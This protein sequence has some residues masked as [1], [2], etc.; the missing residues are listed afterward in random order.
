MDR[1]PRLLLK[2]GKLNV[3]FQVRQK[4]DAKE[5]FELVVLPL[6]RRFTQEVSAIELCCACT[7]LLDQMID[8]IA[9]ETNDTCANVRGRLASTAPEFDT[10]NLVARALKHRELDRGQGK[11]LRDVFCVGIPG[12]SGSSQPLPPIFFPDERPGKH[13]PGPRLNSGINSD[14]LLAKCINVLAGE[15]GVEL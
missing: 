4:P 6:W 14:V 1:P 15:L 9:E 12:D 7:V 10:L 8:W 2:N 11:G 3:V 5:Y 13:P